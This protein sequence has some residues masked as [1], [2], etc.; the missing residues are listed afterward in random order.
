M[1]TL[2]LSGG[3]QA[4]GLGEIHLD[5]ALNE[6]LEA[7]ID[8]VGATAEDLAGITASIANRETFQRFG[9]DRPAFLSTVAFKIARDN[10]GRAVLAIR[11]TD[12][13][14]EP[15]LD[16]VVDLR[17]RGGELIRQYTLLLDPPG[18]P[19]PNPVA[20]AVLVAPESYTAPVSVQPAVSKAIIETSKPAVAA[21]PASVG[22]RVAA[23]PA[24]VDASVAAAE[25]GARKTFRVGAKATLRGVAWRVGSRSNADLNRMMIAIFR[26]NPYAFEGNI[27]RL[28]LGAVLTIPSATEVSAISL[29]DANHEVDAQM[30]GWHAS[31]LHAST[32]G[33][34]PT[35][36]VAP[37]V[38]ASFS[39]PRESA[40]P[41]PV[42]SGSAE[43]AA[44]APAGAASA[45][46]TAAESA[47]PAEM[48]LDGRVQQLERGFDE[49]HH[50]F[51]SEHDALVRAQA[52]LTFAEKAPAAVATPHTPS[53]RGLGSSIAAVLAL[54][55]AAF[56]IYAWRR[57]RAPKSQPSPAEPKP[58]TLAHAQVAAQA[59]VREAVAPGTPV[60]VEQR[61][62]RVEAP[63]DAH[64][65]HSEAADPIDAVDIEA[66]EVSYLL[67]G[68]GGGLEDDFNLG[69]TVDTASLPV[70]V[71]LRVADPSADTMPVETARIVGISESTTREL[72]ASGN[73]M[74]ATKAGLDVTKLDYN[75]LDLDETVQH[76]QMPSALHENVGF[77][78]RRTS[79]VDVLKSAVEREPQRRDLRMK[80]LETYYAAA[81]SNRQGFL[82]TVQKIA[83]ER[84]SLNEGEWDKIA[85]MGRQIAADDVLFA[86]V[87][88]QPDDEDLANCA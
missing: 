66:L 56:G 57:R 42:A 38:A 47:A 37:A 13:C 41:S 79:L 17:W 44:L 77:K 84:A 81:A 32:L 85:F 26:A 12:A 75:L 3:A 72:R 63:D 62:V 83:E 46:S 18:F 28:R 22:A 64:E 59:G 20:K 48:A 1:I 27:N 74:P 78:E 7:D 15:L 71:K 68:S 30:Q 19:S 58:Q 61:A 6:P 52:Q 69:D 36:S 21:T 49:L 60:R 16:M 39:S 33:A 43:S 88:A 14:T 9:L 73:A 24:S 4:L 82:E 11:S 5:S 70:T 50:Q 25:P 10:K 55:A 8:I 45:P 76:V 86:P 34:S 53:R 35:K 51:D 40:V 54:A 23:A 67:Q 29:A 65:T 87:A 80:L 31:T 2:A